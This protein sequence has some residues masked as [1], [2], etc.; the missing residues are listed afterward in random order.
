V[1]LN[2]VSRTIA[3]KYAKGKKKTE[4]LFPEYSQ[5]FFNRVIKAIARRA[6]LKEG[7]KGISYSGSNEIINEVQKFKLIKTHTGRRSFSRL[8]SIAGIAEELIAEE[9]GHNTTTITRHYIG[10]SEHRQ[11][12]RLVQTAWE[13]IL[14][15]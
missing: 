15:R 7:V 10:N 2:K 6:G 11:R 14:K 8:L 4:I 9:M 1:T 5:Q 3:A 13:N 12:I